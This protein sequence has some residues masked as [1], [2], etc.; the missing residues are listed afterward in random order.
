MRHEIAMVGGS[1]IRP[2]KPIAA[3][4]PPGA[5]VAFT[6]EGARVVGTPTCAAS[7]QGGDILAA[8]GEM[9][10][11]ALVEF[12]PKWPESTGPRTRVHVL[13][14][15]GMAI[16]DSLIGLQV[17]SSMTERADLV[18]WRTRADLHP[19]LVRVYEIAGFETRQLPVPLAAFAALDGQRLDLSD[20][21]MREDFAATNMFDYFAARLGLDPATIPTTSRAPSWLAKALPNPPQP[22]LREPYVLIAAGASQPIRAMPPDEAKAL[23]T[24]VIGATGIR[25]AGLGFDLD[26]TQFTQADSWTP[27]FDSFVGLIAHASAIVS[28]DSAAIHIAAAYAIPT[29]GLFTTTAPSLRISGYPHMSGLLLDPAATYLGQHWH[30]SR[31]QLDQVAASWRKRRDD[32]AG[33]ALALMRQAPPR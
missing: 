22:P 30:E 17:A 26:H 13:N 33:A 14:G 20:Y 6:I 12:L 29:L 27:D 8:R 21:A 24:A 5:A 7:L 2:G 10:A 9:G 32:I 15:F 1:S 28:A 23:A 25:V 31:D 18:L 11:N 19:G 16:G 4:G 3:A